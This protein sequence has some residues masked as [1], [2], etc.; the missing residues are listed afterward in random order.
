[1]YNK[2]NSCQTMRTDKLTGRQYQ[3]TPSDSYTCSA[4]TLG[5]Q[6]FAPT[7]TEHHIMTSAVRNII[8][9]VL[10]RTAGYVREHEAEFAE[11][12]RESSALR[13]GETTKTHTRQIIK[14]ER[15]ISE[16]DR[17]FQNLYEDKVNGVINAERFALMSASYENEQE[18]LKGQNNTLQTEL[19]MFNADS[20]KADKFIELVRRYTRFEELTNAMINEFIDKIIVHEGVWTERTEKYKGTR[21]QQVDVYLKYIGNFDAPDLLTPEE[22]EAERIAEDKLERLR[23][24]KREYE[25][26]RRERIRAEK[27]AEATEK[28]LPEKLHKTA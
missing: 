20:E 24:Q 19:D 1:M 16:L 12:I 15:R 2:R 5:R 17:L 26:E 13:Q 9:E 21:T 22:I 11:R 14:N 28:S 25:R 7:C 3:R 10:K 4:H 6:T 23:K 18:E 27:A 8:L